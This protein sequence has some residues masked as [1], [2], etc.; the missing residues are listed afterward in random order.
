MRWVALL[1]AHMHVCFEASYVDAYFETKMIVRV[2]KLLAS[3]N[4]TQL[5][6][7]AGCL[8]PTHY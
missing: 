2:R 4:F 7:R 5:F 6:M 8:L 3:V 1:E